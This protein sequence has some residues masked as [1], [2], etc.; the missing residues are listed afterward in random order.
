MERPILR[1]LNGEGTGAIAS[2]VRHETPPY[3]VV[4]TAQLDGATFWSRYERMSSQDGNHRDTNPCHHYQRWFTPA[5]GP[6]SIVYD[7]DALHWYEWNGFTPHGFSASTTFGSWDYPLQDNPGLYK[8]DGYTG[9]DFISPPSGYASLAAGGFDAIMPGIKADLSLL[10]S[11]YELKDLRSLPRTLRRIYDASDVI[12]NLISGFGRK[13]TFKSLFRRLAKDTGDAHLQYA[14]GLAPLFADI[15]SAYMALL[16]CNKQLKNLLYNEN[17][18]RTRRYRV[19]LYDQFPGSDVSHDITTMP[20]HRWWQDGVLQDPTGLEP[21]FS[22][23]QIRRVVTTSLAQFNVT[24][25]YKYQL[26]EYERAHARLLGLLD[27]LGVNLNPAVI[28]NALPWTFVVD[29]V[30]GISSWLSHAT[31]RNI[32]PSVVILD[33]S[34]SCRLVRRIQTFMVPNESA[35]S[36]GEIPQGILDEEQYI[37]APLNRVTVESAIRSHGLNLNKVLLSSSLLATR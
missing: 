20:P 13:L 4:A 21:I 15:R 35:H 17:K 5:Q 10:N 32:E 26:S 16:N 37:R 3:N 22:G 34:W 14:F 2:S 31:L 25:F 28:W 12:E 30:M 1:T 18:A 8:G 6:W 36:L 29:W 7:Y 24:V 23:M 19:D 33:A 27:R 9:E 11:L